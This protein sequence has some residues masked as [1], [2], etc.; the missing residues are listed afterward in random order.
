MKAYTTKGTYDFLKKLPDKYPD[1]ELHFM[2]GNSGTLAYYENHKKNIFSAGKTYEVLTNSGLIKENGYV[3]MNNIPVTDE[4][5]AVFEDQF[6]TRQKNMEKV[7][8]FQAFRL[9]KPKKGNTYVVFTQWASEK[10][11]EDWKSSAHFQNQHKDMVTKPP[12]YF[13]DRPFVTSYGMIR[14]DE[15]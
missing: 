15:E 1:V 12:A 13:A 7:P 5:K 4:G 2:S 6:K 9:L 8:G 14:R 10:H 3:V 11:Y